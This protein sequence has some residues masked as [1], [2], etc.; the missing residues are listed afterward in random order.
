MSPSARSRVE[1]WPKGALLRARLRLKTSETK[2]RSSMST[3]KAKAVCCISGGQ[4]GEHE[5]AHV[6]TAGPPIF[7]QEAVR[8]V[9]GVE[10]GEYERFFAQARWR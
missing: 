6:S 4:A 5:V 9:F 1:S 3:W 7:A 2:A 8:L 10:V